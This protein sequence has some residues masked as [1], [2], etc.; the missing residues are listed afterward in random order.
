MRPLLTVK[1]TA[2][3]YG[4]PVP[5]I[6][7]LVETGQL[8]V[9]RET[10]RGRIRILRADMDRWVVAHRTAAAEERAPA[11]VQHPDLAGLAGAT[12]YVS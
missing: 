11:A 6:Y 4:Y 12:R 10:P 1:E 2:E 7:R 8:P 9:V 5:T 3:A